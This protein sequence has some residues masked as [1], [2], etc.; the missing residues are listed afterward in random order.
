MTKSAK[1]CVRGMCVNNDWTASNTRSPSLVYWSCSAGFLVLVVGSFISQRITVLNVFSDLFLIDS[2]R[3]L[4]SPILH[5][6][7]NAKK[8]CLAHFTEHSQTIVF[9]RAIWRKNGTWWSH[10]VH[11][12]INNE[13]KN[14]CRLKKSLLSLNDNVISW[15]H[16]CFCGQETSEMN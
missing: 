15:C 3:W 9:V 2:T 5:K 10:W 14:K 8:H 16:L 11:K 4:K 12:I 13:Y 1:V 7:K 6:N